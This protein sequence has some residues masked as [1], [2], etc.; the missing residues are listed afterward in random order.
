LASRSDRI[1]LTGS[2]GFT[3]RPLAERL[4]NDGHEVIG[5][6]HFPGE[7]G[8]F[9]GDLRNADWIRSVVTDIKP[10][11]VLH[12]AGITTMLHADAGE[13]YSANVVGTVN[14][15]S[16]LAALS[17]VPRLVIV[18]SSAT[19]YAPPKDGA[20]IGEEGLLQP[21][22]HYAVSKRAVEDA[23]G[24]YRERLPI[25]ITRPFNYTGPGQ[26]T[27]FLVPKIV[28]HF[29]RR[30]EE[31]EL[32]NLA[33]DRDISDLD[34][35][36]EVYARLVAGSPNHPMTLNICS[37]RTVHLADIVPW[38]EEI[39][40]HRIKVRRNAKLMRGNEPP[41]IQGS[42]A[43]LES[44]LG[45]LPNPDFQ[46]KTLVQMYEAGLTIPRKQ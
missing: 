29:V 9:R 32:G 26:A 8:Q 2:A 23:A 22:N 3:G 10:T 31:I 5:L 17:P 28:D 36:I 33:L 35:V 7:G 45:S 11:V 19:V 13:I 6:A 27:T 16:S 20:P 37:G 39:A 12:L 38:M 25:I 18:A 1:L 40:G 46:K 44:M 14:L 4:R 30:A 21:A 43:K 41:R 24:L 42:A 15:L 34:R